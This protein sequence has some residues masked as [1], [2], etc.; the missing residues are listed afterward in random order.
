MD[1]AHAP[2]ATVDTLRLIAAG[3]T[4]F[5]V[6]TDGPCLCFG[7]LQEPVRE[8]EVTQLDRKRSAYERGERDT[9]VRVSKW[10]STPAAY[11]AG[12]WRLARARSVLR[13][14]G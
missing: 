14:P 2:Q 1:P 6:S 10:H 12:C 7:L 3:P 8:S 9:P 4:F 5:A 11:A 13:R